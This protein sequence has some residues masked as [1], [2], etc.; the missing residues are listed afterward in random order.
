MLS[1]SLIQTEWV[2]YGPYTTDDKMKD[3]EVLSKT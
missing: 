3:R 1:Q 2:L